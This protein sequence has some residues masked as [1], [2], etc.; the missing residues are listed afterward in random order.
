MSNIIDYLKWRGDIPF[1]QVPL[2]EIDSLILS[3]VSYFPF[4]DLIEENEQITITEAYN[5]FIQNEQK[6]RILQID[7]LDLFPMLAKSERFGEVILTDYIN[8]VDVEQEKQFSAITMLLPNKLIYVSYRG[9]DNTLIGWKEDFNMS[10]SSHVPSQKD[11]VKY[12]DEVVK[13]YSG[14]VIVGGHSK[15]GNLAVYA[16]TF[17]D[18]KTKKRIIEV[19][20]ED[21]PGFDDDIICTDQYKEIIEKV[22][23]Y[24]PQ[25]SV[26][27]RLLNHEESY[28]VV[29][30]V[31][32]GIMQ[33]DLYSWQVLG[34]KF[35]SLEEVT[36]GS[37]FV[38]Q[39]IK[40]WVKSV[41][42]EQ[43]A[44]FIDI[45]FE[46]L[47]STEAYTLTE[48]SSK[49]FT[50]AR[51]ILKKYQNIDEESKKLISKTLHALLSIVKDNVKNLK[52]IDIK[53]HYHYNIFIKA[54]EKK[55]E[56]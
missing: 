50:T 41:S 31:A 56:L 46:I 49:K 32:N 40:G 17:C 43:R 51:A 28:T 45:L 55:E 53:E 10:F 35:V 14:N 7:D 48:L 15:G 27:G 9:T 13:K 4:D 30:S 1:T 39:T 6:G 38:D 26:I 8:K 19:Y 42:P 22:H 23:T 21:G 25:S 11:S 47:N 44:Q 52:N 12:L 16:S 5:R 33:H 36:N 2:N 20:N 37:E 54:K 29:Q 24:I 3:R 18:K 34:S